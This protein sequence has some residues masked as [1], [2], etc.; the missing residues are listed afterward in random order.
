MSLAAEVIATGVTADEYLARDDWPRWSQL[1]D[2]E[3]VVNAPLLPHQIVLGKLYAR[4]FAWCE[5]EPGR[6]FVGL[7]TDLPLGPRDVYAPDLWWIGEQRRPVPGQLRL[8]GL[9]DLVVEVR[10]PSTW[11]YD[12]GRKRQRYEAGGVPELWLVDTVA[13]SVL[14]Y[15]RSAPGQPAFDEPVAIPEAGTL[16]SPLLPGFSLGVAEALA[17]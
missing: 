13:R 15:R 6:G 1:I 12:K 7:S 9:P 4:L 17:L 16:T 11:R 14:A 2:G 3:V 10:S 8:V 5:A